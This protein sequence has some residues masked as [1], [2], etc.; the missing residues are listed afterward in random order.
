MTD[1]L[2]ASKRTS[3]EIGDLPSRAHALGPGELK[4]VFGGCKNEG[5]HCDDATSTCCGNLD[6]KNPGLVGQAEC[7]GS[8]DSP[9]EYY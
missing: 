8:P 9:P 1:L 4:D 5:E 7:V 2:T 6:C 3:L